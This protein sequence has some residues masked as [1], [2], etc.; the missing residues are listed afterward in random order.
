M[1]NE[2]LEIGKK[3]KI[4]FNDCC[5]AGEFIGIL[6]DIEDDVYVFDVGNIERL[7]GINS[8]IYFEELGE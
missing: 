4:S 5:V 8:D 7:S 3:Y 2:K 1:E 6:Q